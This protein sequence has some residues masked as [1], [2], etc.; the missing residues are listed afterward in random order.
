MNKIIEEQVEEFFNAVG[1]C[2]STESPQNFT[3]VRNKLTQ[4][5]QERDRIAKEEERAIWVKVSEVITPTT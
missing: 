3:N 1:H 2:I 5:L 4:A